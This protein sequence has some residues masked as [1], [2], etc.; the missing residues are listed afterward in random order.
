MTKTWLILL[1]GLSPLM[2]FGQD[3]GEVENL[4][5]ALAPI[6]HLQ[7]DFSQQQLGEDNILLAKSSGKFR[8]LRPGYFYWEILSPD[9]QLIVADPDYLWHFDRDLET[10]TRRPVTSN[11]QMAPMQILGGDDAALRDSFSVSRQVQGSFV[12][13]PLSSDVGFQQLI[14]HLTDTKITG[15]EILDNLN[16]RI[17]ITFTGMDALS[18]LLPSDFGFVPPAGVDLFYYDE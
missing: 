3:T 9:Q 14:L 8:L 18:E 4:L 1:L 12:L 17:V 7:G 6:K 11:T 2:T 16:Q 10:V 13:T 15:M 5:A